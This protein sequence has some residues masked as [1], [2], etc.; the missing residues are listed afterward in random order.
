MIRLALVC[1]FVPSLALADEAR[2]HDTGFVL[3][4]GGEIM[5]GDGV[6]LGA[7]RTHVAISQSFGTGSMRP[8]LAF[9]ATLGA[10]MLVVDEPRALEGSVEVPYLDY[11]P[12]LQVGLAV[13]EGFVKNRVF[14]SVAYVRASVDDRRMLDRVG[15]LPG[16]DGMRITVGANWARGWARA[17]TKE[18]TAERSEDR[19]ADTFAK[20]FLLLAPQQ[21]EFGWARSAGSA[22]WGVTLSYG[23]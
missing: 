15:A 21:I 2:E 5:L 3:N 13:G 20:I 7:S 14:A 8:Q 6:V 1:L 17:F 9:G 11:G 12:E 4:T 19:D 10:G 18:S 22:R 23:I 16:T